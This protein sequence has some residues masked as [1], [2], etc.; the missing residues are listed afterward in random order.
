MTPPRGVLQTGEK[1]L[2]CSHDK[3]LPWH[4]QSSR[5]LLIAR[6]GQDANSKRRG[7]ESIRCVG[8]WSLVPGLWSLVTRYTG[9]P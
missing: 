7:V 3:H 5:W 1:S 6:L 9:P 8:P 4:D 2:G